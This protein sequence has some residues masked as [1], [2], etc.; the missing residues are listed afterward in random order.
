[1]RHIIN[2][3]SIA[4]LFLFLSSLGFGAEVKFS[5]DSILKMT[6]PDSVTGQMN[7]HLW[8]KSPEGKYEICQTFG[9]ISMQQIDEHILRQGIDPRQL[10]N[11]IHRN[12]KAVDS[13]GLGVGITFGAGGAVPGAAVAGTALFFGGLFV[14]FVTKETIR[15]EAHPFLML[16]MAHELENSKEINKRLYLY[17][18]TL[19]LER[20]TRSLNAAQKGVMEE[21]PLSSCVSTASDTYRP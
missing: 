21:G 11:L 8:C 5:D 20:L 19:L 1:M 10:E 13:V 12:K 15:C 7:I 18:G 16:K 9:S 17:D 6:S 4:I 3:F 14:S 2:K